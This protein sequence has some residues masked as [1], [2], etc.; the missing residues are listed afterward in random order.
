MKFSNC[1]WLVYQQK[2][3]TSHKY[4][5]DFIVKT[6]ND[7]KINYEIKYVDEFKIEHGLLYYDNVVISVLPSFYAMRE[8]RS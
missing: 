4:L 5:I 8:P 2:Y 7:V 1:I 3:K 6:C